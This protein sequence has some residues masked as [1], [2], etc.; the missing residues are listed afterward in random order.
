MPEPSPLG[1][2]KT[3]ESQPETPKETGLKIR[4]FPNIHTF[5]LNIFKLAS[6][7]Y[8]LQLGTATQEEC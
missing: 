1:P 7:F 6:S 5:Y 2:P 4:S 8:T 3:Q